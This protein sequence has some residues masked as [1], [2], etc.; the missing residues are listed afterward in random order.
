MDVTQYIFEYVN[1]TVCI[2]R[3]DAFC[4]F[5]MIANYNDNVSTVPLLYIGQQAEFSIRCRFNMIF[6]LASP[7]SV[8]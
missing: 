1:Y 4:P 5:V 3:P 2:A 6:G 8:A 7:E